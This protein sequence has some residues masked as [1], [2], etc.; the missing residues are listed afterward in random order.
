MVVALIGALL[1][2]SPV[3]AQT[4]VERRVPLGMEGSFRV[5]NMVGSVVIHGWRRDTVLVRGTV[6]AGD[7]LLAGGSYTGAK[8]FV[9]SNDDRNPHPAKLEIWVPARAKVWVKTATA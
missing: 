2:G 9:E 3:A 7:R 5:F 4:K 6:A 8:I 1:L